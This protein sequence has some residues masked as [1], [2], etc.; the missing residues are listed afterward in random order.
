MDGAADAELVSYSIEVGYVP[1][2]PYQPGKVP[3]GIGE[4]PAAPATP[5]A[6]DPGAPV[7]L[8]A[9]VEAASSTA[10]LFFFFG[11]V[12]LGLAGFA[13][14]PALEAAVVVAFVPF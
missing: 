1:E 10:V 13:L 3:I 12:V 14:A 4:V 9:G 7:L 11:F 5:A 6:I 2:A 8:P